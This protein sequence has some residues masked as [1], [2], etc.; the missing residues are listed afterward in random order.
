[1]GV[2]LFS[3]NF[4]KNINVNTKLFLPL[5]CFCVKAQVLYWNGFL[6]IPVAERLGIRPSLC[7]GGNYYASSLY[8]PLLL[9]LYSSALLSLQKYCIV[10]VILN[11]TQILLRIVTLLNG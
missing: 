8:I 10:P 6:S 2:Y 4:F 11:K 1:M 5:I 9:V 7:I 3:S